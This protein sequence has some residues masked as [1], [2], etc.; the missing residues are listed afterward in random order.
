MQLI[1][2]I[3]KAAGTYSK[4]VEVPNLR[5]F[6][7]QYKLIAGADNTVE[8]QFWG[9]VY[10]DANNGT[11]DDWA[12]ITEFL[13]GLNQVS[14]TDDA[15]HDMSLMDTNCTF[16]KIKVKYIVTAV[17]P[18]NTIKVGWSTEF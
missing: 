13:T 18:N 17:T 11:D 6:I 10:S 2:E 9:T 12:N 3:N 4:V 15:I 5:N 14:V 8:L 1:S 16:A 7:F